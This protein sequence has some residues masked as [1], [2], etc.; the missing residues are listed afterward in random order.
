MRRAIT[1]AVVGV[2]VFGGVAATPA[3]A[4]GKAQPAARAKAQSVQAPKT[5]AKTTTTTAAATQTVV[6]DGYELRVP[7]RWPVYRLDQHPSAC[8]RYDISA[9]YL[10]IPG[11]NMQCPANIIG[12]APTV[13]VIP[14]ATVAAGAGSEV[15]YQSQQPDGAGGTAV[16]SVAAVHSAITENATE[17]ELR[18]ALGAA[19]LGATV[20]GTYGDDPAVTEQ[21]LASL[22]PAPAG[23]ADSAQTG[24]LLAL[25]APAPAPAAAATAAAAAAA[26]AAATGLK[27]TPPGPTK[28]GLAA[29]SG[30]PATAPSAAKAAGTG[31]SWPG[32]PPD[33]PIQIM[34]PPVTLPKP[35]TSHAV[36]GFDAC[37]APPVKAMRKWRHDYSAI[38]IYIGGAN[39][40]CYYGN[41]SASW[42]KATAAMGWKTIPT[43]VGP[44]APC[45]GN[46]HVMIKPG[47][48]A[49]EGVAAGRDAVADARLFGLGARSPIYYDMEAYDASRDPGCTT[50]VL[51]FLG[52]WDREV[53]SLGYVTGVYSSNDSGIADMQAATR[54]RMSGF[55][56]PDAIWF[57][58]WDGRRSL[59]DGDLA[60][61]LTDRIK[62]YRGPHNRTIGGYTV[63]IDSD[64]ARG[65]LA[66]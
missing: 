16:R 64:L 17:H 58:S 11:A 19:A 1:A 36:R 12:G 22:R 52:A 65:P 23:A 8:V 41:L 55:T 9:V 56:R 10:G 3:F 21:V 59:S 14:S 31:V 48:A 44:Q 38:G 2:L 15:T 47:K 13:S 24:S 18:V 43:Y 4:T 42:V 34:P 30:T 26:R 61:S 37:G 20:L 5:E 57:A 46:G 51:R 54:S 50:A 45:W 39:V 6:Y 53:S 29:R 7:A 60:W 40:G 32:V 49:A 33:W 66:R 25:S 63:N 35:Q 28:A 62:Q 27:L